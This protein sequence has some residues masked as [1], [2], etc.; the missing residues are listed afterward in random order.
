MR[1]RRGTDEMVGYLRR[2]LEFLGTPAFEL[3]RK[4]ARE[5]FFGANLPTTTDEPTESGAYCGWLLFDRP[6]TSSS[7]TPVRVFVEQ[8]PELPA[9]IR[10]NLL[11][12]EHSLRSVFRVI[13]LK[14][15]CVIVLD[16]DGEET[17][18]YRVTNDGRYPWQ[19]GELVVARLVRWDDEYFFHG[20]IESWPRSTRDLVGPLPRRR[21]ERPLDGPEHDLG[22][23]FMSRRRWLRDRR[24]HR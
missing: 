14:S 3:E 11:A 7:A 1:S 4:L 18:Y 22:G 19:A 12:C 6:L 9:R 5:E 21:F 16:L 2:V 23:P 20:P 17:D 15:D 13:E 24:K 8:H 10:T